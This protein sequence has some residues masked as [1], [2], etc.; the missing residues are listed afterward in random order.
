MHKFHQ[1]YKLKDI[2]PFLVFISL[3]IVFLCFYCNPFY[4]KAAEQEASAEEQLNENIYALLEE[5]DLTALQEYVNTLENFKSESVAKRLIAYVKGDSFDY[6]NF[7]KEFTSVLFQDVGEIIPSFA[8]IAAIALLSGL[9]SS[10]RSG[11]Q[12]SYFSLR[13]RP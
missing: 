7:A 6:E 11:S 3:Y 13:Q 4:G 12:G 8:C 9:I 1:S 2:Y 5:L 10:L